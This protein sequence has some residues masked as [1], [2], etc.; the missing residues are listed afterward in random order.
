MYLCTKCIRLA[1]V[2]ITTNTCFLLGR[3]LKGKMSKTICALYVILY[4][5][6]FILTTVKLS[7]KM[8]IPT[9]PSHVKVFLKRRGERSSYTRCGIVDRCMRSR[10]QTRACTREALSR[11][12][13][14]AMECN[15][16]AVR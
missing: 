2:Y 5:F 12:L 9:F 10:A 15:A 16:I 14:C 13:H 4:F 11:T 3:P 8:K 7:S 6:E 1:R